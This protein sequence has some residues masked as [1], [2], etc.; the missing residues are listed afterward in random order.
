MLNLVEEVAFKELIAEFLREH[1]KVTIDR[2]QCND[3]YDDSTDVIVKIS[4]GDEVI[5]ED[6]ITT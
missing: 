4:L 5:S 3:P 1:L 2:Y 6:A